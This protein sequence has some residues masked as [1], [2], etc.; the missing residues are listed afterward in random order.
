MASRSSTIA[1]RTI[2]LSRAAVT[3]LREHRRRQLKERL[4]AGSWHDGHVFT[5]LTGRPLHSRNV[6]QDLQAALARADLPRVRFHVL[7]H[8]YATPMLEDGDELATVSRTL[9]HADLSTTANVDAHLTRAML[10]PSADRM[11][12]I[13]RKRPAV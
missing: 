6:T 13:L 2:R 7:R 9:G 4:A 1:K 11:D 5:T 12:A 3:A 10:Q 8:A